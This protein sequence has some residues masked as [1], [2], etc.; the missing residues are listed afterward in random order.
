MQFQL[1]ISIKKSDQQ[2]T[3]R[4]SIFLIGS[5]FTEHIGN[6]L[7]EVKLSVFQNPSGIL[8]NPL[9][10]CET[11]NAVI[12]NK[13]V[14]EN[15]LFQLNEVWHSWKHHSRF[16]HVDKNVALNNINTSLSEAH[17]FLKEAD[18]LIIT[19]GSAFCYRLSENAQLANLSIGDGVA[20]CHRAPASWF[21]KELLEIDE[22]NVLLV[23]LHKQVKD[24]N[25]KLKIIF[26]ISP[27]RHARDGVVEN[28]RSKARLIESVHSMLTKFDS[29]YYFPSY[30]LMIDVLRDYRFYDIDLVHPN[31]MAT[32]FVLNKF[33]ETFMSDEQL[34]L[35]EELK[36][37]SIARKHKPFHSSTSAHQEFLRAQREKII[38]LLQ[39]Y[40][41]LNLQEE[42]NYFN[43]SSF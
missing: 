11:L 4:D 42:L 16:S 36:K 3:Y 19:L 15:N 5:C 1:P 41:Y 33:V 23:D 29:L 43:A 22:I 13:K 14:E 28:N 34:S 8:F 9:S 24:F 27:V 37:I 7:A 20:N 32:E 6:S 35:M 40:P 17:N 12:Q 31:Y 25:S 26:T 38:S 10:V 30:E 18:W 2:I 21:N 39:R